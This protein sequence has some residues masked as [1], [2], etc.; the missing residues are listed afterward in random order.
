MS[1][2]HTSRETVIICRGIAVLL[3]MIILGVTLAEKQ[4]NSLTQ[5]NDNVQAI[6]LKRDAE[7]TY[8]LYLMGSEYSIRAVCDIA[9]IYNGDTEIYFKVGGYSLV[10][11]KGID[12]NRIEE[13]YKLWCQQFIAEAFAFKQKFLGYITEVRQ[14]LNGY[15]ERSGPYDR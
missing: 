9:R 3:L 6:N 10:A 7:G 12:L 2:R 15:Y 4:L 14:E 1:I 5:L 11:P 8:F 13:L